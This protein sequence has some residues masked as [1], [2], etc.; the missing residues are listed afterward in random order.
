MTAYYYATSTTDL[1]RPNN[2]PL[3]NYCDKG[4][5][6]DLEDFVMEA[7]LRFTG[8]K[9]KC[10]TAVFS[11]LGFSVSVYVDGFEVYRKT[12]LGI[13]PTPVEIPD[14]DEGLELG[15]CDWDDENE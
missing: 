13:D 11:N 6:T 3:I 12:I 1:V 7:F 4:L 15:D 2:T 5:Y 14:D 10:P 9:E 8:I